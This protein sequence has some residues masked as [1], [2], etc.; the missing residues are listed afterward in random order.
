MN[1]RHSSHS[2]LRSALHTSTR[3]TQ[4]VS[5][6]PQSV[7]RTPQQPPVAAPAAAPTPVDD[8]LLEAVRNQAT[9]LTRMQS[10]LQD[11]DRRLFR[12]EALMGEQKSQMEALRRRA[13]ALETAMRAL[14][15][16]TLPD[17]KN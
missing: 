4:P 14:E 13:E 11:Q 10:T 2:S 12:L 17:H 9:L 7:N 15:Q 1:D 3:T 16:R 5:R 6:T 8:R